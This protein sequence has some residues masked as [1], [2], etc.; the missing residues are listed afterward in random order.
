MTIPSSEKGKYKI[1]GAKVSS[2]KAARFAAECRRRGWIMNFQLEMLL[3]EFLKRYEGKSLE[4][5]A[6]PA[7]RSE[8]PPVDDVTAQEKARDAAAAA[9]ERA[10]GRRK[11]SRR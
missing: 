3:E 10:R 2:E 5:E 8:A 9:A 7:Q 11:Q 6:T 4:A 1:L